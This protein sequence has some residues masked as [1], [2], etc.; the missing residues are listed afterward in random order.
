MDGIISKSILER[1]E[2]RTKSLGWYCIV[3]EKRLLLDSILSWVLFD[4]SKES[5]NFDHFSA[6]TTT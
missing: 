6:V 2:E 3:P 1:A 4:D 5:L